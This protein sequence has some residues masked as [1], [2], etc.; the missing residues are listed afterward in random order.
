[1]ATVRTKDNTEYRWMWE[2]KQEGWVS[3]WNTVFIYMKHIIL[4]LQMQY[5]SDETLYPCFS[6]QLHV[7][8]DY[9]FFFWGGGCSLYLIRL[10]FVP[11]LVVGTV[12][13]VLTNRGRGREREREREGED[14]RIVSEIRTDTR[15]NWNVRHE[16]TGETAA[17]K[18]T[19]SYWLQ[20]SKAVHYH[21]FLL[22]YLLAH[23]SVT[24]LCVQK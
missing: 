23:Y 11:L 4:I 15:W 14:R 10:G 1:M 18:K 17:K 24:V 20:Y 16:E 3:G 13:R 22:H 9:L 21:L 8:L 19:F 5:A 6:V 7:W 12:L 2:L